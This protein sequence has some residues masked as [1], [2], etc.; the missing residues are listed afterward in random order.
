MTA[1]HSSNSPLRTSSS[2]LHV[3]GS[4]ST[5]T[6]VACP[7]PAGDVRKS[8]GPTSTS[9]SVADRSHL[10]RVRELARAVEQEHVHRVRAGSGRIDRDLVRVRADLPF[11]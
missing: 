8:R 9:G 4:G 1:L 2:R 7:W 3:P 11:A 6:A 5:A 10:V